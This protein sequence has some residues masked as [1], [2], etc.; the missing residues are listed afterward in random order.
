MS[1]AVHSAAGIQDYW[2]VDLAARTI[3]VFRQP[4]KD[5][6]LERRVLRFGE[7]VHPLAFPQVILRLAELFT[8]G[9]SA[10]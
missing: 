3:H 8:D 4:S 6:Y 9:P 1:V 5:G 2:V 7:E 10:S